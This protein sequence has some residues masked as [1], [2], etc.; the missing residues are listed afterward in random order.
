MACRLASPGPGN[1]GSYMGIIGTRFLCMARKMA[2]PGP[3]EYGC[4]LCLTRTWEHRPLVGLLDLVNLVLTWSSPIPGVSGHALGLPWTWS[5]W[6]PS[7]HHPVLV[8]LFPTWMIAVHY[9]LASP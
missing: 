6:S 8:T 2:S 9:F 7:G 4:H 3:G 1:S 5:I